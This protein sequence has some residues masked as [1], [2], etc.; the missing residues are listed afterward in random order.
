MLQQWE[1]LASPGHVLLTRVDQYR[2]KLRLPIKVL[3]GA[4]IVAL[5]GI[6]AA[7]YT[8]QAGGGVARWIVAKV[9]G[10]VSKAPTKD[11]APQL[12]TIRPIV[13]PGFSATL[14]SVPDLDADVLPA[15]KAQV[16]AAGKGKRLEDCDFTKQI[17][18]DWATVGEIIPRCRYSKDG[19][20]LWVWSL[21]KTKG[22]M[23]PWMG[24]IAEHES[25]F[26]LYQISIAGAAMS[27][28][29]A[30]SPS[31]LPHHIPRAIAS[32]F[33][34]LVINKNGGEK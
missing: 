30:R 11:P 1:L 6:P 25:P 3:A 9:G 31:I 18:A 34:E 33:P 32:D 19:S 23:R 21:V 12:K 27:E 13:A 4:V 26:T 2:R 7:Y 28:T 16:A 5:A 8:A 29:S 20:R 15:M 22:Q 14:D 17:D 10:F 24:L